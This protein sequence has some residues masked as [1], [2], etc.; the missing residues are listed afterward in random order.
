MPE[1]WL[2]PDEN[3]KGRY[4]DL[5]DWIR[6]KHG[7]G[8]MLYSA[9]SGAVMLAETGLL[10]GCD[11][12][13]HWGYQD[14]FRNSYP[15]VHFRPE[16]NLAFADPAGRIVTA[17]GT[18]SWHDLAIHIISRH[19]SPAEALRVAKVYLL[20]WHG[21]GQLPYEALVRRSPQAD[22]VVRQCEDFLG[23]HFR[24]E[25]VLPRAVQLANIPE[26]TLKRRFRIAT[27]SSLI[28]RLQKLRIEEAKRMLENSATPVTDIS[29]EIGYEDP[30]F[31]RRLFKRLTGVTP[32]QYRRMFQPVAKAASMPPGPPASLRL[33]ADQQHLLFQP[34]PVIVRYWFGSLLVREHHDSIG[35]RDAP[36]ALEHRHSQRERRD[37]D[38]HYANTH[39]Q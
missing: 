14:L 34:F 6:R 9:C 5:M 4:P 32:S 35:Y 12:T 10:D 13:S 20:K 26:R 30:S 19:C 1:L 7:Q 28:E 15:K 23:D 36:V 21:E 17:G 31:F 3:L 16:P 8:A 18:T 37:T 22:S 33:V 2:G 38:A 24:E 29:F 39:G 27:G 11:A 25:G